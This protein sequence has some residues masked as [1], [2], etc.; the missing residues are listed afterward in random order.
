M[1]REAWVRVLAVGDESYVK[2][3]QEVVVWLY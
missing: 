1:L 2:L 3:L